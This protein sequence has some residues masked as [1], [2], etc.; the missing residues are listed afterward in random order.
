V[1]HVRAVRQV[2]GAEHPHEEL[3]EEGR[4]VAGAS[5]GVEHRAVRGRQGLELFRQEGEGRVPA[6]RLVTV[7]PLRQQ[8]RLGEPARLPQLVVGPLGQLGDGVAGEEV[9]G[10]PP[11]GGLFGHGLGAV[12]AE[13]HQLAPVIGVRPGAARAVEPAALVH[14]RQFPHRPDGAHPPQGVPGGRED[15]RQAARHGRRG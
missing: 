13:S 1:A 12:L 6:H 2:V 9:P 14:F 7:G 5:R 4:F 10:D 15:G 8:H 3:V 11:G